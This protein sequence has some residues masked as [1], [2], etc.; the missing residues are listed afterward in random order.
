MRKYATSSTASKSEREEPGQAED[1]ARHFLRRHLRSGGEVEKLRGVTTAASSAASVDRSCVY[2]IARSLARGRTRSD[3]GAVAL[4]PRE[5]SLIRPSRTRSLG[6]AH[7]R[8][9]LGCL[10]SRKHSVRGSDVA[11]PR[12]RDGLVLSLSLDFLSG[13]ATWLV[14]ALQGATRRRQE[15]R[16][17]NARAIASM[18]NRVEADGPGHTTRRR[19]SRF[20]A[21]LEEAA[22]LLQKTGDAPSRRC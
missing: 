6:G 18:L 15:R 9:S 5:P 4:G 22:F 7:D 10:E 17:P 14:T 12:T 8:P 11:N 3:R 13:A 1:S 19:A 2:A 20:S 21:V 16:P